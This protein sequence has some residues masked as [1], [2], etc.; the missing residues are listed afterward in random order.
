MVTFKELLSGNELSSVP[1]NHQH[2]LEEL[3]KR[4]NK[5]R[6][7]YGKPMTV[8]S[9]YRSMQHHKD[10]YRSKGVPDSK[11][12]MKSNHLYGRACDFADPKGELQAFITAN[13]PLIEEIGLWFEA[14]SHTKGWVHCQIIP[15]AS[16]TRFFIP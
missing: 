1:I 13:I 3:L 11:I 5:L 12:P 14:F 10:I 16:G 7:A 8:S 6:S 2:N 4:V 9:G 15:P